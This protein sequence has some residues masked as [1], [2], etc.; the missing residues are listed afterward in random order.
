MVSEP[1]GDLP[2]AWNEVPEATVLDHPGRSRRAAPL[3]TALA[4][5]RRSRVIDERSNLADAGQDF[6]ARTV[7]IHAQ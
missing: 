5:A 4:R 3:P 7:V 2:G 6:L 1:L